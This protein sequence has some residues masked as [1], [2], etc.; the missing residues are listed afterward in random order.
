MLKS[1]RASRNSTIDENL[2]NFQIK[3]SQILIEKRALTFFLI[4]NSSSLFEIPPSW[5]H[6]NNSVTSLTR[7]HKILASEKAQNQSHTQR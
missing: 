7:I 3:I 4:P 1:K 6:S 5:K 2:E